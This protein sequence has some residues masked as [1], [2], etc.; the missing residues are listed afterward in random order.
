MKLMEFSHNFLPTHLKNL[1]L[2][3]AIFVAQSLLAVFTCVLYFSSS[4]YN[5]DLGVNKKKKHFPE[6]CT[7]EAF[8]ANTNI[9]P[10]KFHKLTIGSN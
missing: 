1:F 10:A 7:K 2:S 5:S 8:L 3:L 9:L 4:R 6:G